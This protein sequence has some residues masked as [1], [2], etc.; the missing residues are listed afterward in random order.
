MKTCPN[1]NE[2]NGNNR[3]DCWKCKASLRPVDTYRKTCPKCGLVYSQRA[4]TCEQCG[5][6][7]SVY[8][9]SSHSTS[10]NSGNGGCWMY[11]L[12][13]LFPLFGIILGCIYIAKSEDELGKSLIIT[14]IVTTVFIILLTITLSGC[15]A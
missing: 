10:S 15:S 7:L 12:A 11:A 8:D 4:E 9:D 6:R 2:L 1:C 13:I 5:G 3:T 14:S